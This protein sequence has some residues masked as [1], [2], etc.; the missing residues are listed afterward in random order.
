MLVSC[1]RDRDVNHV[2]WKGC[3]SNVVTRRA[4]GDDDDVKLG[5]NE[6]GTKTKYWTWCETVAHQQDFAKSLYGKSGG[7]DY[8]DV[9][10][11]NER[12]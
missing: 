6:G 3:P 5:V 2:T 4:C 1:E 12:R 8:D 11:R 7:D 9:N 10:E